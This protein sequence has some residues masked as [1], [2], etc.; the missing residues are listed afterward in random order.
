MSDFINHWPQGTTP[1]SLA[2]RQGF[3][4]GHDRITQGTRS[5]QPYPAGSPE[6]D[7]WFA[8]YPAGKLLAETE[9]ENH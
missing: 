8:G 6:F 3:Q 9:T 5:H 7:A 2:Y 4:A 1:R